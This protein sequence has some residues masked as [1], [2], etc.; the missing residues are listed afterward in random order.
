MG[1]RPKPS[2]RRRRSRRQPPTKDIP[3]AKRLLNAFERLQ[4]GDH[5]YAQRVACD[6]LE[7]EPQNADAWHLAG[8][9]LHCAGENRAAQDAVQ[10]AIQLDRCNNASIRCTWGSIQLA[11][12]NPEQAIV[13]F[14][15]A[16]EQS[17]G[18]TEAGRNL[19]TALIA[20]RDFE[21]AEREL[22]ETL[23]AA[24][25]FAKAWS[26]L[27]IA[28]LR[29]G[30]TD[31]AIHAAERATQLD[32][33]DATGFL[34]LGIAL[35]QTQR[36]D[37]SFHALHAAIKLD[38]RC[39][40]AFHNMGHTL[41]STGSTAEAVQCFRAAKEI[42]ASL[43]SDYLFALSHDPTAAPQFVMQEHLDWG[44]A[45]ESASAFT[46]H[47]NVPDP[48]R[49]LRIGYVS[50]D[51]R[52]HVMANY[53]LPVFREHNR[54][55][56]EIFAYSAVTAEDEKTSQFQKLADQWRPIASLN[57]EKL[58]QLVR[59]DK[60]DVLVD[61]AGH[62][63]GNRLLAMRHKP[64]PI[65][66]TWLGYSNTTGLHAID[67]RLANEFQDPPDTELNHSEDL[68]YV[69]GEGVCYDFPIDAP[70]VAPPP[71]TRTRVVTFGSLH[72]LNK[73][74][75]PTLDLWAQVLKAVPDS[76]LLAYWP[77]LRGER[78]RQLRAA[79]VDRGIDEDRLELRYDP[80]GASYLAQY[81]DIDIGLDVLPWT[82][83][84]TTRE[85]LWMGVPVLAHCGPQRSSRGSATVLHYAGLD[86]L[87]T[88]SVEA[89]V[90]LAVELSQDT[91][92]LIDLRQSL[93]GRM[94]QSCGNAPWQVRSIESAYR[95]MWQ[96]WCSRQR[97]GTAL[98]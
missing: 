30:R 45:V 69:E 20:I 29:Q 9:A 95:Q 59:N 73:L 70:E 31:A 75:T 37:D 94:E 61:L 14:R 24:P 42:D 63:A 89:Y 34:N 88:R 86:D 96:S 85:A 35:L 57:D 82:G 40:P 84:T 18:L 76:R 74:N 39:A 62:T 52:Q 51:Y 66:V 27:S 1:R 22:K 11:L 28:L 54:D 91:N 80:R 8:L 21:G 6:V 65:Q 67:Y 87:V 46:S 7:A 49:R 90:A 10:R 3:V 71:V 78:E 58:V 68:F 33:K 79:L 92:R 98:P 83:S 36:I 38:P 41:I 77:T 47:P 50:P 32:P 60:I 19:G 25:T 23:R 64:A 4:E 15:R 44:R 43:A 12:G 2:L 55:A 48:D 5:T 97:S 81:H 53:L 72:R 26:S 13:A 17:P 56:F 16:L 93:R